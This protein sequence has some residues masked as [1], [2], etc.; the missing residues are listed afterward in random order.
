MKSWETQIKIVKAEVAAA[1]TVVI[2]CQKII[3][4][5]GSLVFIV[6]ECINF[7]DFIFLHTVNIS[8]RLAS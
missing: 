4:W 6:L 7:L 3:G 1:L 2:Q 8:L 5:T